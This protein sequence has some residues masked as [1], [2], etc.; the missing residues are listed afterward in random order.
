MWRPS[1]AIPFT[2]FCTIRPGNERCIEHRRLPPSFHAPANGREMFSIPAVVQRELF[3]V[4]LRRRLMRSD[5]P[6]RQLDCQWF[7]ACSVAFVY[8]SVRL[9]IAMHMLGIE[10][11]E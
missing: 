4:I 8:G 9:R 11:L 3:A 6:R 10:R 7:A 5:I 1:R 2:L